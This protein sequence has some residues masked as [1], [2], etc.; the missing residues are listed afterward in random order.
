MRAR[1]PS[2]DPRLKKE[3]HCDKVWSTTWLLLERKLDLE[4]GL[5][6]KG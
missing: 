3:R 1:L 6:K 4:D 5:L 2:Y